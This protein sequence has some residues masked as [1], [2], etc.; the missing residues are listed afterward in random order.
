MRLGGFAGGMSDVLADPIAFYLRTQRADVRTG[1]RVDALLVD[2]DRVTGVNA[3]GQ[4]IGAD[5]VVLAASVGEAQ[6]LLRQAFAGHPWLDGLLALTA[7]PAVTVQLQLDEPALP[8]DRVTFGPGT[9]LASFS[10]QSRTTFRGSKGR[11]SI[12]LADPA[13]HVSTPID[14]LVPLVVADAAR[15][16][17]RLEGH[18]TDARKTVIPDDFYALRPGSEALRPEQRTPIGGLVLAGDYTKQ[19]F[20]ATME[21]AVVS[22]F[23]AAKA[24]LEQL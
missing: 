14:E 23:R 19:P 10:E 11:L 20:L 17:I 5:A 22:G 8:V 1:V 9:V 7:T 21:G 12:I 6:R 18:V 4:D 13:S 2:G 3:G 24:L 15:L 16:G